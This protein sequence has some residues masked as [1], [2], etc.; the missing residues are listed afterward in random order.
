LCTEELPFDTSNFSGADRWLEI[1]VDGVTLAPRQHLTPT[2]YATTAT[3]L[4]GQPAAFYQNASNINAGTL[5]DARLSG[6]VELLNSAQAITGVKT[7]STAP[8]FAAAGAPF[9]VSSTSLVPNLNADLLD[10]FNPSAFLQSTVPMTLTGSSSTHIIRGENTS[11]ASG[12]A[13]VFGWC[14]ATSGQT[15]Q[16]V[17][18]RTSNTVGRG[19]FGWADATTGVTSGVSGLSDSTSGRGVFG[20]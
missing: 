19:V 7:F 10:G 17:Y 5:A 20:E 12:A 8:A 16:G 15:N 6:N 13:G 14:S 11:V 3:Q 2:P 4:N 9:S 1:E 18:G